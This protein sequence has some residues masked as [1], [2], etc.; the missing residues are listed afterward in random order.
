MPNPQ[1][2]RIRRRAPATFNPLYG[3]PPVTLVPV[4]FPTVTAPMPVP[5]EDEDDDPYAYDE[6]D[7]EEDEDD[8]GAPTRR[9][10]E[11][12][13]FVSPADHFRATRLVLELVHKSFMNMGGERVYAY[14][15]IQRNERL[16]SLNTFH[17]CEP[18]AQPQ[19]FTSLT[20][21][22][23]MFESLDVS[24]RRTHVRL[25][26]ETIAPPPIDQGYT[27]EEYAE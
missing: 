25:S 8:E 12:V 17:S 15:V 5:D 6:D 10:A 14:D 1:P 23:A 21:A 16:D 11:R 27:E 3:N 4:P 18:Y 20:R 19:S 7:Y 2:F 26:G 24:L 9:V 22:Q 13:I